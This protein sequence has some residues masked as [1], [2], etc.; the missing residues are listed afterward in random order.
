MNDIPRGDGLNAR[1][2]Y[3]TNMAQPAMIIAA[4]SS[5]MKVPVT[6]DLAEIL[7]ISDAQIELDSTCGTAF[8][9]ALFAVIGALPGAAGSSTGGFGQP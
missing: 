3:A 8:D 1:V 5:T 2:E 9:A 7:D 6:V 4:C